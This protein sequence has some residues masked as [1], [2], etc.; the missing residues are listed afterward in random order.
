M[1][2]W[3]YWSHDN[4]S[5]ENIKYDYK[6]DAVSKLYLEVNYKGGDVTLICNNYHDILPIGMDGSNTY[7]CGW[8]VFVVDGRQVKCHFPE[9]A[10]G[11]ENVS[12]QITISAMSGNEIVNTILYVDR[13][14]GE[15]VPEPD[16]EELSDKYKFKLVR[17]ALMP[18]MY[19]DF[20][21]PAPLDNISFKIT[22]YYD[23]FQVIGF[24]E[25]TQYYDS[26]VWCADEFPNTVRVYERMNM[27]NSTEEHFSSQ[28]STH[29]FKSADIKTQLKGYRD[30]KVVFSTSLATYIFER[31]FLCYD[32][33]NGSVVILNPGNSGVYCLLDQRYEYQA[34]HTQEMNGTRY[35]HINVWNK[36]GLSGEELLSHKRE[37]L[38]KLMA[39]NIGPAQSPAGKI[40]SFKC[41]PSEG[42]EAM[43]FWENKTTRI[44]LLHRLADEDYGFEDYYL[45]FEAK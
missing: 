14:F 13:Y 11:K 3:M 10:L 44:I 4:K 26:I 28:W 18:F 35:A 37:G 34:G 5:P 43:N 16:T 12:D 27:A 32:W 25:F 41:L 29:F 21:I 30:G 33:I 8:G 15:L 40:G 36:D 45:H 22:D 2:D 24:P 38:V 42:V 1:A 9:D 39:D 7:D 23:R 31:D 20:S 17:G 6:L 19:D